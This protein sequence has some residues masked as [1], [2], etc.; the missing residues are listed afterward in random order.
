MMSMDLF[1]T[2]LEVC[3]IRYDHGATDGKTLV[4]AIIKGK[5]MPER[6]MF[7]ANK[8]I[9]AM[10]DSNFKCVW[11]KN[12]VELFDISADPEEKHDLGKEYPGKVKSMQKSIVRWWN[13]VTKGNRLE[14]YSIFD[15][16]IPLSKQ[17]EK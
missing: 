14:G 3:G 17:K 15:L 4:E 7:W 9:C 10:K 6:K 5:S 12:Q 8:D 16:E 11:T 2:I 1:P 13:E